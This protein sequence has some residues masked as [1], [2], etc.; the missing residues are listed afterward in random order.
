MAAKK[1]RDLMVGESFI[2]DGSCKVTVEKKT[3]GR[4]R[5]LIETDNNVH[6][7]KAHKCR[8][9]LVKEGDSHGTN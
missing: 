4:V 8:E 5:L 7:T 2:V 3:G 9:S 6:F 1:Y